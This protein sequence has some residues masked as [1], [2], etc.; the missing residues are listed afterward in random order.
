M[1]SSLS[2][3]Q[4]DPAYV[5]Q[6]IELGVQSHI[7]LNCTALQH[8]VTHGKFIVK[9][10]ATWGSCSKILSMLPD[11]FLLNIVVSALLAKNVSQDVSE[12]AVDVLCVS[13]LV[14]F[15]PTEGGPLSYFARIGKTSVLE[16]LQALAKNPWLHSQAQWLIR[17]GESLLPQETDKLFVKPQTE[18]KFS[19]QISELQVLSAAEL[20]QTGPAKGAQ[21]LEVF[22]YPV[23]I[24]LLCM[25][26]II[27]GILAVLW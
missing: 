19:S 3:F 21:N 20:A 17:K 24:I 12:A 7:G 5:G 27:V 2:S 15:P 23:S 1:P 26:L 22:L 11:L 6:I 10:K 14:H 18:F 9:R 25:A 16:K 8:F 13:G 4:L